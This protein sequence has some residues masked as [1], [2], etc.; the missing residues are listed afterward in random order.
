MLNVNDC[1]LRATEHIQALF[2]ILLDL[3]VACDTTDHSI[4]IKRLC[5][6]IS[7]FDTILEWVHSY[8]SECTQSV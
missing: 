2:F 1:L 7:S 8:L 3:S 5:T 4:L 6:L